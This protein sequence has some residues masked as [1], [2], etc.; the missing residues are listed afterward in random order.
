MKRTGF[1]KKPLKPALASSTAITAHPP[2]ATPGQA[3]GDQTVAPGPQ[4]RKEPH[5]AWQALLVAA[6][7]RITVVLFLLS[8]ALIFFGTWAQVDQG[9]WTVVDKYFRSAFV[10]IPL[11]VFLL[12]TIEE[13]PY[14]V[15]Y[16]GGWLLGGLLLFNLLAAHTV[17]FKLS[18]KRSG[19]LLIHAGLII[20]MLS[21]LFT[22]LYAVEGRMHIREGQALNYVQM[23]RHSELAV[24]DSSD[25]K[26]DEVV[27]IPGS[28]LIAAARA[29][30]AFIRDPELP[31]DIEVDQFMVN[32]DLIGKFKE[33]ENLA[34][35]GHGLEVVAK[36]L[37]EVS[38]TD[39]KQQIDY[40]SAYLTFY[41]KKTSQN[42]GTFLFS[43][44]FLER[45]NFED[46]Q[47]V[48]VGGKEY[49]VVLRP[50][51]SYRD[52]SIKLEKFRFDRYP[53]TTVPKNYQ[54][55]V[56]LIDP[57]RKEKRP[58]S[59]SMNNPLRYRGETFY[60][61]SFPPDERGTVLQ[62]VE[63][64]VWLWPYISC[65][66]VTLGLLIHFGINLLSFL[67][68]RFAL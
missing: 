55:D 53:G 12:H 25:P 10:L 41:D 8:F 50:K 64:P 49:A 48:K 38:G 46:P 11:R 9:I 35:A 68:R 40:P 31:F 3:G 30:D 43:Y 19:I 42:L 36:D 61:A 14:A 56:V 23:D 29:E 2:A 34:K 7:L 59:I 17:R 22:G 37:P 24:I 58:V 4:V 60:Q 16:P 26:E 47:K 21:E 39:P 1:S 33:E 32:S 20:M 18:W 44:H 13:V 45:K 51:R 67:Q 52:F 5:W 66:V 57:A 54:S 63:N 6:S 28:R 65:I 27:S 62:V 15:P